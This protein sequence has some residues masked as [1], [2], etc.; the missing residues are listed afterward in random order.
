MFACC[1]NAGTD[2]DGDID[3]PLLAGAAKSRGRGG[4]KKL[5]SP[6]NG[7]P[8]R[9][10]KA[11]P[12]PTRNQTGA[13]AQAELEEAIRLARASNLSG[14]SGM[15]GGAGAAGA[16]PGTGPAGAGAAAA[17]TDKDGAKPKHKLP[18]GWTT[19]PS[20][21]RPGCVTYARLLL[22]YSYDC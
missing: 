3:E 15:S 13:K 10:D 7:T 14:A 20:R 9:A 18:H 11:L 21:S 1:G 22:G 16:A 2:S 6:I 19:A 8:E 5:R 12:R 17:T 4:N